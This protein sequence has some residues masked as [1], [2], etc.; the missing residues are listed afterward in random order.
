LTT[1][2][3][4]LF[5]SEKLTD[6]LCKQIQEVS[7][8]LLGESS[9]RKSMATIKKASHFPALPMCRLFTASA[10]DLCNMYGA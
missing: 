4:W 2:Y 9:Y 5:F 10:E 8:E 6:G 1:V 7:C 3:R